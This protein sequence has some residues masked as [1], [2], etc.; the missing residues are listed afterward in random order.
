MVENVEYYI[1]VFLKVVMTGLTTLLLIVSTASWYR[2]RSGKL[3]LI[4]VAFAA[5]FVKGVIMLFDVFLETGLI[6]ENNV[7]L[8]ID[9]LIIVALYFSAIKK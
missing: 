9:L 1:S 4:S 8:I 2:M 6:V 3:G 7:A 5:F